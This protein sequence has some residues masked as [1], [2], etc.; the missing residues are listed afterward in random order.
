MPVVG[1]L[2]TRLP[3]GGKRGITEYRYPASKLVGRHKAEMKE[4][5]GKHA[6]ET[7]ELKTSLEAKHAQATQEIKTKLIGEHLQETQ[8]PYRGRT[9]CGN[10]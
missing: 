3:D 5:E 1:A 10:T 4:M 7:R 8:D 6:A 9:R 2:S